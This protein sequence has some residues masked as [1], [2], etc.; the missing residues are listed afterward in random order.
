MDMLRQQAFRGARVAFPG[1]RRMRDGRYSISR[2]LA[3]RND[4]AYGASSG[5]RIVPGFRNG[6]GVGFR[7]FGIRK[8]SIYSALGFENG[9]TI[10][11]INGLRINSA[12]RALEIYTHLKDARRVKV[13]FERHGRTMS[14]V[15]TFE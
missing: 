14:S 9:D 5:C 7:L 2:S 10:T 4:G 12:E 8:D 1:I 6:H 11:R 3:G 15:F 13:E